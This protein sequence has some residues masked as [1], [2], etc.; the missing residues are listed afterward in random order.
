MT[1][2]SI[3]LIACATSLENQTTNN[4]TIFA[5]SAFSSHS[6]V[7]TVGVVQGVVLSVAKPPMSKIA[8]VFGRFEAFSL[9]VFIYVIG[10]IQQSASDSVQTYAAAQ[11]FYAAGSTG[12]QILIQIFVADTSDLLNR[13]FCSAL[14]DVPF[15]ATV[16]IGPQLAEAILANLSWRWGYGIW[17]VVLPLAFMPLALALFINQRKAAKRGIL[18]ES[19]FAGQSSSEIARTLWYELDVFGLLLLCAAFSLILIP[20]TL[21]SGAGWGNGALVA[22]LA[23]GVVC[24]IGFPLW[25]RSKTLAPRAF[26]PRALLHNRTAMAGF[27]L[28]FFYFSK[29]SSSG[30]SMIPLTICSGLLPIDLPLLSVL[31]LGRARRDGIIRRSHCADLYL[32]RH[33]IINS[34]IATDQ[35]L[36]AV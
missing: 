26:F 10:Y 5:T 14:P 2:H 13:A 9:S 24:L 23:I 21:A 16:W 33:N 22:M 18:P 29:S 28:A 8:D 15:L 1:T 12:L 19:P 20:L 3:A 17:A 4:L 34:D 27:G 30:Q 36:Q 25:E 31:S 35:A 7:A 11:I 32:R 6:L